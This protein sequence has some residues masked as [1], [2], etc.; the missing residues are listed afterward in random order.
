MVCCAIG[1]VLIVTLA[2]WW[3]RLKAALSWRLSTRSALAAF[4]VVG[5]ALAASAMTVEHLGHTVAH[6]NEQALLAD[7]DAQPICRG[8]PSTER[9][10]AFRI[11]LVTNATVT[12]QDREES[13]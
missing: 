7:I 2:I 12:R 5:I 9:A 1:T 13:P 6:A 11:T 3:K 8:G 4:A 10:A